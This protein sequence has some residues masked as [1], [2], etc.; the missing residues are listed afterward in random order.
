MRKQKGVTLSGFMLWSIVFIFF[1]FIGLRIG[2]S[3][4]EYITIQRQLKEIANSQEAST[5]QRRDV[6]SA[7]T[8]RTMIEDIKSITAKDLI[9]TKTGDGIVVSAEY[10]TCVPVMANLRACMDFAPTSSK[11]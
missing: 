4:F 11:R 6:E 8:K 1:G 10:S 2:P 5:G 9:I 3:Y 7:F